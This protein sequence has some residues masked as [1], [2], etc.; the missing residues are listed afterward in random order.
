MD[1]RYLWISLLAV[2]IGF[3]GG[4][5]F[6]NALN[7]SELLQ[8]RAANEQLKGVVP[9]VGQPAAQQPETTLSPEEIKAKITEADANPSDIRFQKGLGLALYSYGALKKDVELLNEAARILE[10]ANGLDGQDLSIAVALGNAHFDAGYFGKDNGRLALSREAYG[11]ALQLKPDDPDILTD[12]GLSY[13]LETPPQDERAAAEFQRVLGIDPKH[14][15]ALIFLVQSYARLGRISEAQ[16]SVERLRGVNPTSE[17][18]P[19]LTAKIDEAKGS[20]AQ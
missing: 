17:A 10:R 13:F 7:R 4:F 11:K 20:T 3:A 16:A 15:K 18:I 5:L 1:K 19:D 2:A 9:P 6:A 8:L 14:E 12:V